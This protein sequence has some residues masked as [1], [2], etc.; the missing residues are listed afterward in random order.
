MTVTDRSPTVV[1][2]ISPPSVIVCVTLTWPEILLPSIPAFML[3]LRITTFP[4]P[5]GTIV[6]AWA[7]LHGFPIPL[8]F[9]TNS[10]FDIVMV[11]LPLLA[12]EISTEEVVTL[13]SSHLNN[14]VFSKL[15]FSGSRLPKWSHCWWINPR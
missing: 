10:A 3:Q 8:S 6:T 2:S 9:G 15:H 13:Y 7:L 12:K 1:W 11:L 4:T 5:P 14:A